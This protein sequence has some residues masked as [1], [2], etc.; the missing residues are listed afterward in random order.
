MLALIML[1]AI[2]SKLPACPVLPVET[3]VSPARVCDVLEVTGQI[4]ASSLSLDPAFND[5]APEREMAR[6]AAGSATLVAYDKSGGVIFTFPFAA[7]GPFRL[8]LPLAPAYGAQIARL[9]LS[10]NG[11]TY[12]RD[13]TGASEV[14]FDHT[15]V[16][17]SG[18][19][20]EAVETDEG[21]IVF[22]WDARE[23]P[24][25]RI[26]NARG[27]APIATVSGS[28]TF[29]QIYIDTKATRLL[30]SFSDGVH[31]V[32]RTV[33]ITGRR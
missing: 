18:A 14:P 21:H 19:T 12:D 4:D 33:E 17:L 16:P 8:V 9:T 1:A 3:L 24:A 31:S 7:D 30:V 28:Q 11:A 15:A 23:Y 13:G 26:A 27:G 32:T 2:A 6:P 25:V 20:A 29:E 5:R 22:A 10:A